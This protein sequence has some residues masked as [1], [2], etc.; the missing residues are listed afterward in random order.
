ML[1][2]NIP[3]ECGLEVHAT[4]PA[5]AMP[6]HPAHPAA[7]LL[8]PCQVQEATEV[9]RC[10]CLR[11]AVMR[12]ALPPRAL[13]VL[14][15]PAAAAAAASMAS[16]GSLEHPA[17]PPS[18]QST[19]PSVA[20]TSPPFSAAAAAQLAGAV[21]S[22]NSFCAALVHVAAKLAQGSQEALEACPFLSVS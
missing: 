17:R 9:F 8:L 16:A 21:M 22:Y 6:P 1:F 10:Y 13:S 20:T 11:Q 12:G 7:P 5:P 3:R 15:D 18:S 14:R 19:A 4:A 2:N